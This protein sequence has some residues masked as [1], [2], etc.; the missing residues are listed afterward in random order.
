MH[1]GFA[2]R[3]AEPDGLKVGTVFAVELLSDLHE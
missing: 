2:I 3:R 1:L